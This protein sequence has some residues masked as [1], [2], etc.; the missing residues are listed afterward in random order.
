MIYMSN[1]PSM[2]E[3]IKPNAFLKDIERALGI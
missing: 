2:H 3:Q 1:A